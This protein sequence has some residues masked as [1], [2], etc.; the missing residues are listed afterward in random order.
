LKDKREKEKR[1]KKSDLPHALARDVQRRLRVSVE[2][3]CIDTTVEE[4]DGR[5]FVVK[6]RAGPVHSGVGYERTFSK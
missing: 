1:E 6:E 2:N 4:E 5:N 3:I